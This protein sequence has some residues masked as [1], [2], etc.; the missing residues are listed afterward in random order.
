MIPY[1]SPIKPLRLRWF[2]FFYIKIASRIP[3]TGLGFSVQELIAV[4][5]LWFGKSKFVKNS[6]NLEHRTLIYVRNYL[7]SFI[8]FWRMTRGILVISGFCQEIP[9]LTFWVYSP[10]F[11]SL[12]WFKVL[13]FLILNSFFLFL[14]FLN[15]YCYLGVLKVQFLVFYLCSCFHYIIGFF[16]ETLGNILHQILVLNLFSCIK[17]YVYLIKMI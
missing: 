17:M 4:L 8:K 5:F 12:F 15:N 9:K 14:S 11:L 1:E 3:F 13:S 2:S 6:W 10:S 7:E 16:I